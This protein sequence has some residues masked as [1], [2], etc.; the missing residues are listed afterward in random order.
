[1]WRPCW[2]FGNRRILGGCSALALE[3]W[4]ASGHTQACCT[5]AAAITPGRLELHETAL[6]GVQARGSHVLGAF[7]STGEYSS[8]PAGTSDWEFQQDLFVTGGF[9][10]AQ[11]GV[12]LGMLES[13]RRAPSTGSE[14]GWG[15]GDLSWSARYDFV[16]VHE[17]SY[18][19]GIAGL[20][21]LTLPTGRAP[22]SARHPLGSDATGLGTTQG[23]LGL[24]VE[25]LFAQWL[26]SATFLVAARAPRRVRGVES[27]LAPELTAI[28][29]LG[30]AFSSGRSLALLGTITWEG[31]AEVD[32]ARVPGT[33]KRKLRLTL[34][35]SEALSDTLRLQARVFLDPPWSGL[36]R[37]TSDWV[38]AQLG[39][40][41]SFW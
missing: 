29:A 11:A 2:K 33:E 23:A 20:L 41:R 18:W 27:R 39:L 3:L 16:R 15:V 17:R 8:A 32:G 22:E 13:R 26:T 14:F 1:M 38:G 24:S 12:S 10:R 36:G 25:Q 35:A 6:V 7:N 31:R 40:I 21:G 34:A 37:N 5:S 30:Y 28:A 9:G 19:P 4:C